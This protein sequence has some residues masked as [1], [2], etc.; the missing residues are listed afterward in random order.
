MHK[1]EPALLVNQNRFVRGDS[2]AYKIGNTRRYPR[3]LVREIARQELLAMNTPVAEPANSSPKT[4]RITGASRQKF[5]PKVVSHPAPIGR[6][7]TISFHAGRMGDQMFLVPRRR[8]S[9]S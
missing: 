7:E 9:A 6:I 2:M 8:W 3:H 4:E 5:A 1:S